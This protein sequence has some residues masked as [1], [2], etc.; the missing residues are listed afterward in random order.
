MNAY[1]G[2][3]LVVEP[4][5]ALTYA[6]EVDATPPGVWPW[7][8]QMGYHRSGWYIDTWWDRFA[9]IH[10]W[11]RLVP[12]EARG[13]YL[14]AAEEILPQFQ[15]LRVGDTIPDGPPGTAHYEVAGLEENR[16]L[17]LYSTSHFKYM[18]PSFLAGT[19]LEPHGAF[20]WTFILETVQDSWRR[21]I[22]RWRG[23]AG[24]ALLILPWLP[25][26]R[27]ADHIHQKEILKGLKRRVERGS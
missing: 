25:I 26:V 18:A 1:P 2:D 8:V 12:K 20:S 6:I 17:L 23:I 16:F 24:P 15:G 22:S 9:Q 27:I 14:P 3:D 11:P 21:I 13:T 10:I 4:R 5:I 19:R 7:I